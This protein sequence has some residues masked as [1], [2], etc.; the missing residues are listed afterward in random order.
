MT[1]DAVESLRKNSEGLVGDVE[2]A[3]TLF[4]TVW[5]RGPSK[6]EHMPACTSGMQN[7]NCN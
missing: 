1:K 7:K 2:Q 3:S 6:Q 4:R 5:G